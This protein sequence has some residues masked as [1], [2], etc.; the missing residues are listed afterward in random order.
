MHPCQEHI[1]LDLDLFGVCC[2]CV[3]DGVRCTKKRRCDFVIANN[4]DHNVEGDVD[5]LI[6]SF[7]QGGSEAL[8]EEQRQINAWIV[9]EM[10]VCIYCLLEGKASEIFTQILGRGAQGKRQQSAHGEQKSGTEAVLTEKS[11]ARGILQGVS[12]ELG[13]G[14]Q[15]NKS[16]CEPPLVKHGEVLAQLP[17]VR[18]AKGLSEGSATCAGASG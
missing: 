2:P 14:V 18:N 17:P 3:V 5:R 12:G 7:K 11:Q 6:V 16:L 1:S 4:R 9:A 8:D 13:E 10:S 15:K